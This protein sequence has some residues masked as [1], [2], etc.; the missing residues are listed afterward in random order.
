[1]CLNDVKNVGVVSLFQMSGN[2]LH[3]QTRTLKFEW[4]FKRR[5]ISHYLTHLKITEEVGEISIPIVEAK[6][7]TE[8]PKTFDGH[9]Q[10][11]WR[12]RWIDLK[13]KEKE[14][15]LVKI[16]AFSTNVMRP[17]KRFS[18][19]DMEAQCCRCRIVTF[20]WGYLS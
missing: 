12:T 5:Q 8:P 16:K 20:E 6:P 1:M 7:T 17:N 9:P 11:D 13:K 14:S 4:C 18:I 3:F 19:V 15:S 2:L 10:R